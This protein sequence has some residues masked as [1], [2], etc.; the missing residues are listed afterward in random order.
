MSAVQTNEVPQGEDRDRAASIT[1]RA[2]LSA[3][4]RDW[5]AFIAAIFLALLLIGV[6]G[7]ISSHHMI[8][9]GLTWARGS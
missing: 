9:T 6:A 8:L 5:V 1:G 2:Y 7:Q 3:L 4:I